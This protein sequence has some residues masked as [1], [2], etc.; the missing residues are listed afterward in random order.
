VNF[1]THTT[2][3]P[4]AAAAVHWRST[5]F[6]AQFYGK[7]RRRIVQWCHD[8]I[9]TGRGIPVYQDASKRWWIALVENGVK[10]I[11]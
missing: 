7:T 2:I 1:D 11:L 6:A 8:G 5:T 9:F 10:T 4:H 3:T